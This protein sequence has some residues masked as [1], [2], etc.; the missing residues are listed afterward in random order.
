[1]KTSSTIPFSISRAGDVHLDIYDQNGKHILSLI[2]QFLIPAE[3][4]VKLTSEFLS[5]GLYVCV[6]KVNSETKTSKILVQK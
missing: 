3:Y 4:S 1:L 5:N 2:N 6:L